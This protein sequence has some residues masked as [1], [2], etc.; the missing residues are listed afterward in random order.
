MFEEPSWETFKLK[1]ATPEIA[2]E[3]T[4]AKSL[5]CIESKI[6][7]QNVICPPN[8]PGIECEPIKTSNGWVSYQAK[9]SHDGKQNINQFDVLKHAFKR[10]EK[11]E[12][13]L[14][15]IYCYS[16]GKASSS[17]TRKALE[18]KAS[19]YDIKLIWYF[20]DQILEA[21]KNP[22][23]TKI[24][25]Y[26]FEKYPQPILLNYL[27]GIKSSE[28]LYKYHF[29][30]E[31]VSFKGRDLELKLLSEFCIKNVVKWAWWA[32]VGPG[33]SGKSRIVLKFAS[34]LDDSWN[35]GWYGL[36]ENSFNFANWIPDKNTLL[37]I[38]YVI[39]NEPI[40]EK[41]ISDLCQLH[42]NSDFFFKV[43]LLIIERTA[44]VWFQKLKFLP[45]VGVYISNTIFKEKPLYLKPL[46]R[47]VLVN[48]AEETLKK[49]NRT[50]IDP[51]E[52]VDL[53]ISMSHDKAPLLIQLY[54]EF[55]GKRNSNL[56]HLIHSFLENEQL[57]RW[58]NA[59]I[60]DIDEE[61]LILA[62]MSNGILLDSKSFTKKETKKFFSKYR[63]FNKYSIMIGRQVNSEFLAPLEP[64]LFGE[65]FVLEK[66]IPKNPL[67]NSLSIKIITLALGINHG[68]SLVA[69]F[70]RCS[71]D[72]PK[73]QSLKILKSPFGVLPHEFLLWAITLSNVIDVIDLSLKEK[74]DIYEQ[75]ARENTSN[76]IDKFIFLRLLYC[77]T[78]RTILKKYLVYLE[79]KILEIT[80]VYQ[81]T[82][83]VKD[84]RDSLLPEEYCNEVITAYYRLDDKNKIYLLG[85]HV[86]DIHHHLMI[87]NTSNRPKDFES[88]INLY[89][90]LYS[91]IEQKGTD[92][93]YQT[94]LSFHH[95]SANL[96]I[97]IYQFNLL[98]GDPD[99]RLELSTLIK[100]RSMLNSSIKYDGK[101]IDFQSDKQALIYQPLTLYIVNSKNKGYQDLIS[102][103]KEFKIKFQLND[104]RYAEIFVGCCVQLAHGFE[105]KDDFEYFIKIYDKCKDL[106]N[107]FR[108]K[109]IVEHFSLIAHQMLKNIEV[110]LYSPYFRKEHKD[111]LWSDCFELAQKYPGEEYSILKNLIQ[112][113]SMHYHNAIVKNKSRKAKYYI[114]RFIDLIHKI[115][116]IKYSKNKKIWPGQIVTKGITEYIEKNLD[117]EVTKSIIKAAS[118][119][120]Y[121]NIEQPL[122]SIPSQIF[123]VGQN[124]K[125]EGD[126]AKANR[127]L[128]SLIMLKPYLKQDIDQLIEVLKR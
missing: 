109:L 124:A 102:L 22:N 126:T 13:H 87:W 7:P 14:D 69:F 47:N 36:I 28:G 62:T 81:S 39:G 15:K 110:E 79:E 16:S 11:R 19:E 40:L 32:I 128:E 49:E 12:Y 90:K 98:S 61:V 91:L 10:K 80:S 82:K 45:N 25:L 86:I 56:F 114:N 115:P 24:R 9:Y 44:G 100:E 54:A 37:I 41:L 33:A 20:E 85:P 97:A 74:L 94:L 8:Y 75:V 78:K 35:W 96:A 5:F 51:K 17:K 117:L 104:S 92:N 93:Y 29:S 18:K 116:N 43:R 1:A 122:S 53:S 27:D 123:N 46:N 119:R 113:I 59:G 95:L 38:D 67:D 72:F 42:L 50:S 66:L 88:V 23:L 48:I 111:M 108:S 3:K 89:E 121:L 31:S 112:T 60:E 71:Q 65:L 68:Q 125:N 58:N 21:I 107:K 118:G 106:M 26:F 83:E 105:S 52:L 103:V 57:K 55:K 127:C 77:L 120:D 6:L 63:S 73:H 64:D 34:N 30:L 84:F 76:T 4:I 2:F 101:I 70:T 99:K